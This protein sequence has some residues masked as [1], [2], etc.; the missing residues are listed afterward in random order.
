[1]TTTQNATGIH[2]ELPGGAGGAVTMI[3][4]VTA[5][6]DV[7]NLPLAMLTLD[8]I[9]R[10]T[11]LPRSTTHRILWQL[12]QCQWVNH[13]NNLYALGPRALRLGARELV[14]ERLRRA[15]GSRL[16]ELA[17]RTGL[18][19]HLAVIDGSEIYYV[20]KFAGPG[21][22][23][24]PSE[25]GRRAPAHCTAAGKAILAQLPPEDVHD[26]FADGL[27][28]PNTNRTIR[29]LSGLHHELLRIRSKNGLA[30]E[31]GEF[32]ETVSCIGAVVSDS[33]GPVG[34]ISIAASYGVA[35]ERLGPVVLTTARAIS[36]E[37]LSA[38][39]DSIRTPSLSA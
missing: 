24:V 14:Y 10:L 8:E 33:M 1:M 32:V 5:I 20:D 27:P 2:S 15:C 35:V 29:D 11:G 36:A 28:V 7:F 19:V 30:I 37:L 39:S 9:V 12:V 21:A 17:Y 4:R 6:L 16:R 26:F 34:A 18:V 31:H 13:A 38:E 25:V 23:S 22:P 3:E